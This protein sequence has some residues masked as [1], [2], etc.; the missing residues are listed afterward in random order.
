MFNANDNTDA[1]RAYNDDYNDHEHDDDDVFKDKT[2]I[3]EKRKITEL[4]K[5]VVDKEAIYGVASDGSVVGDRTTC[6][7]KKGE[8]WDRWMEGIRKFPEFS[9]L[10]GWSMGKRDRIRRGRRKMYEA[11]VHADKNST[12]QVLKKIFHRRGLP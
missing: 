12:I 11:I 4:Y 10:E 1:E 7:V 8:D 6:T 5:G 3:E 2:E 9:K